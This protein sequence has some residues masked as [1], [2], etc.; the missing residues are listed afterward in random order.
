[1]YAFN[2]EDGGSIFLQNVGICLQD[3]TV[4][5]RRR[6]ASEQSQLERPEN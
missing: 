4:S 6:A 5:Q 3:Y 1:M 2:P